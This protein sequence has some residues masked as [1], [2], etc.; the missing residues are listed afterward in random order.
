M[1]TVNKTLQD[2]TCFVLFTYYT[3]KHLLRLQ[4]LLVKINKY[5]LV[6]NKKSRLEHAQNHQP[7]YI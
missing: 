1:T 6:I 3:R 2:E 5:M 7:I 4:V